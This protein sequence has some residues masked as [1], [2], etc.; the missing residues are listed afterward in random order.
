MAEARQMA[1]SVALPWDYWVMRG[2][3]LAHL[4]MAAFM[5]VLT[6]IGLVLSVWQTVKWGAGMTV[7]SL[8][9]GTLVLRRAA[10]VRKLH[11]PELCKRCG[12]WWPWEDIC[13]SCFYATEG[14]NE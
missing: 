2:A 8:V 4:T 13:L 10:N 14:E 9:I 12:D 1:T 6:L 5:A 11:D 3:G 7:F